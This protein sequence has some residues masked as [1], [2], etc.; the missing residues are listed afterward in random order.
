MSENG[1]VF[2]RIAR[3]EIPTTPVFET[4]D[5]YAFSDL[6]PKAPVHVLVVPKQHLSR[7]SDRTEAHEALLGR[8]LS[9]AADVAKASGLS[10]FRV[11]VNDGAAAG[12]SVFHLHLHVLGGRPFAWPPG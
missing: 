1:C 8:C 2:C 7:L 5:V 10:D 11:V 3:K 6:N 9:A 12:Q 4:D